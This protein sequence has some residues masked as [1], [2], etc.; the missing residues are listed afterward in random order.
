MSHAPSDALNL[1]HQTIRQSAAA[2]SLDALVVIS[3][4]NITYLTNFTG[5][6]A[7][8]VVTADRLYFITDFRY[9]TAVTATQ[10]TSAACPGLEL[11]TVGG[12]Y[13][14]AL[15][16]LL[17]T[18][19]GARIGFEAGHLTVARLNWLTATLG[20]GDAVP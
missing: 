2:Q 4:P 14:A 1:R 16:T 20:G 15:A 13:D 18:F 19:A 3:L 8:V 12:S 5:S 17:Q 9:I 6:S 7:I 10:D 11:V